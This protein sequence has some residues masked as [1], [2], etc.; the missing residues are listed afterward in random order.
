MS[1]LKKNYELIKDF[2]IENFYVEYNLQTTSLSFPEA[3]VLLLRLKIYTLTMNIKLTKSGN[4]ILY[5][6]RFLY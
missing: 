3:V 2:E 5:F 6:H 1:F 4:I